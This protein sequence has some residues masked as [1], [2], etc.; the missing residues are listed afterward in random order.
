M[1]HVLRFGFC[2][3]LLL[4]G[5]S[6]PLLPND[7]SS[8]GEDRRSNFWHLYLRSV[9]PTHSHSAYPRLGHGP[10]LWGLFYGSVVDWREPHPGAPLDLQGSIQGVE[11]T[12]REQVT[13]VLK[14]DQACDW[15]ERLLPV[16]GWVDAKAVGCKAVAI[17]L[18]PCPH[19]P[20]SYLCS[21]ILQE[22]IS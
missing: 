19:L 17:S 9:H 8:C 22:C 5:S 4:S 12:P 13:R 20:S 7:P 2:F 14:R 15:W 11:P 10:D 1:T 16:G 6:L 3:C 18:L 21:P